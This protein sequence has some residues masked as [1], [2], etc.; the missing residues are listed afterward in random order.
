VWARVLQ[1]TATH[2][3]TL[4][5]TA[6]RRNIASL[7]HIARFLLYC[8]TLQ[9][10]ATHCNTLQHR[11][12]LMRRSISSLLQHTATHFHLFLLSRLLHW[13]VVN[14]H[15]LFIHTYTSCIYYTFRTS[16]VDMEWFRHLEMIGRFCKRVLQK[17][18]Y[19]SKETYD[20]KEPTNRNH[21][22]HIYTS[23]TH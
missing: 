1:H 14:R 20:L 21:S 4:Q 13:A 3:N 5:H 8:N 19:Y 18:L 12:S 6:T 10:T 2:C 9:H 22:I 7:S 11:F 17:R 15:F 23:R 16:V